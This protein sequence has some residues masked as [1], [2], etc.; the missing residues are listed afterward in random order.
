[1]HAAMVLMTVR[2]W[3]GAIWRRR[4]QGSTLL[5]AETLRHSAG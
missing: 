2:C 5:A 3:A 4:A 1:M